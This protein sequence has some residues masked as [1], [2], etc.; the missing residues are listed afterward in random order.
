MGCAYRASCRASI[1]DVEVAFHAFLTRPRRDGG[2]GFRGSITVPAVEGAK[3]FSVLNARFISVCQRSRFHLQGS[4]QAPARRFGLFSSRDGFMGSHL[5]VGGRGEHVQIFFI[6]CGIEIETVSSHYQMFFL[7]DERSFKT[8]GIW[9]T[10]TS[11][12]IKSQL[13]SWRLT[14]HH[15]QSSSRLTSDTGRGRRRRAVP[16]RR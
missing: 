7:Y 15:Q 2:G 11:L 12:I 14:S 3:T 9:R 16:P 13:S 10:T 1:Y 6:I 5:F 4:Q 8:T